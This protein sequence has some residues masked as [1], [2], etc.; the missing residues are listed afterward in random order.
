MDAQIVNHVAG[1]A[2]NVLPPNLNYQG[3][4]GSLYEYIYLTYHHIRPSPHT[5]SRRYDFV[6]RLVDLYMSFVA[7]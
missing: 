7:P 5:I 1:D 4:E 2:K 6:L 3:S